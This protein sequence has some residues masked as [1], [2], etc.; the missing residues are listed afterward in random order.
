MAIVKWNRSWPSM[1]PSMFDDDN[2]PSL[3][4]WPDT[5][6]GNGLNIYETDNDVVVEAQVPGI[7][8]DKVEVSVEGGVLSISGSYEET[9][10][11]KDKK[12]VVYKNTRQTSFNYTTS[13]PRLVDANKAAATVDNG[14]VKVTIPKVEEEKPKKILVSKK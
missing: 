8:E 10:E 13:L 14:V 7:P 11:E 6:T 9:E 5:G 2:L 12:K 3:V 1:W 4:N